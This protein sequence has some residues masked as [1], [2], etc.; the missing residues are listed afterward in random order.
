ME[1]TRMSLDLNDGTNSQV[2]I[3]VVSHNKPDY[4]NMCL[5]SIYTMTNLNN[6]ELIVVDNASNAETQEYLDV[7]ESEDVKVIRN[8][9]NKYWSAAA[10][11]GVAAADPNSHYYVFLH[12]DTIVLDQSWIDILVGLAEGKN[13]GLVGTKL[14]TLLLNQQTKVDYVQ[15]WCLLVSR[16]CWEDIGPWPE[17]LPLIGNSFI[18]TW[19]AQSKGY[20]PCVY[21]KSL[22]H[23][24]QASSYDLNEYEE[25]RKKSQSVMTK[26]YRGY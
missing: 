22:V 16:K 21:P 23:H 13:S 8:K 4:L 1:E 2:S 14:A 7:L 26:L 25:L 19:R 15:E 20:K 10:N 12:A 18:M 5:Q 17:E 6:F 3:I 9:E 11:Q 24:Y